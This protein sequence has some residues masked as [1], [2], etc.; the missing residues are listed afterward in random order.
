VLP[1]DGAIDLPSIL[2]ALD[3]AGWDGFYDLEIFSDN[4]AFGATY[5]DSLWDLEPAELARRSRE[6][7]ERCWA[8]RTVTA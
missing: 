1:G 3:R 5:D 8:R 2:G 6:S 4:G 7:F